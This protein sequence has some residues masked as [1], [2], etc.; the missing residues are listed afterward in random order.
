MKNNYKVKFIVT[1]II[2]LI[3]IN[4][5]AIHAFAMNDIISGGE[6]FIKTGTEQGEKI[7]QDTIKDISDYIYEV[8]LTL[9]VLIAVAVGVVL[10]IQF[11]F[12]TMEEQAKV[13]ES[14]VPYVIGCVVIFGAF[15]IWYAVGSVASRI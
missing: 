14:L 2:F 15:G 7:N 13:K 9:G 12:G 10:G 5:F 11:M 3:I 1:I 8:L 6:D 4:T